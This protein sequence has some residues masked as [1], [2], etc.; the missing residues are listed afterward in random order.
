MPWLVE[1]IPEHCVIK[2]KKKNS[3]HE[4][5]PWLVEGIPEHCVIK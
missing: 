4:G 3:V 2:L 5:M 1:G